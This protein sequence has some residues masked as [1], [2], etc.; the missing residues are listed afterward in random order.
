AAGLRERDVDARLAQEIVREP[1]PLGCGLLRPV[2]VGRATRALPLHPDQTEV[3]A[4]CAMR[5]IASIEE[6]E[7]RSERTQA[8]GNGCA[9]ESAANDGDFERPGQAHACTN[10][11][12]RQKRR[13]AATS[14]PKSSQ[15][16]LPPPAMYWYAPE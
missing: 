14:S 15:P 7:F 12:R 11:G 2:R 10:S 3:R 8:E 13:I 4:R 6:N 5:D 9:D 1:R 16:W